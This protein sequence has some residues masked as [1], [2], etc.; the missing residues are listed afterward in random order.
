MR[1]DISLSLEDNFGIFFILYTGKIND[2]IGINA[3][4]RN[5][6]IVFKVILTDDFII[7]ITPL[8]V[9][10]LPTTNC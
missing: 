9:V 4:T 5:N 6:K 3:A 1:L 7:I 8:F 10:E 2:P